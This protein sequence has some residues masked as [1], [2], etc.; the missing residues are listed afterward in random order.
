MEVI[1]IPKGIIG[2]I[3]SVGQRIQDRRTPSDVF[4]QLSEEVGELA[5]ELSVA[6]G[7][8]KKEPGPDRVPG[9]AVDVL[10]CAVDLVYI[11]CGLSEQQIEDLIRTKLNKWKTKKL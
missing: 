8:S 10:I 7:Y 5:T 6:K 11:A 4:L 9:E 2:Q 1:I 3:L